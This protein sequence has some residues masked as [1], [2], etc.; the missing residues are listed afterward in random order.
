[1][2]ILRSNFSSLPFPNISNLK[3]VFSKSKVQGG[4]FLMGGILAGN[5]RASQRVSKGNIMSRKRKYL[6]NPSFQLSPD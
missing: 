1:M 5:E 4:H 3:T 6:I 2:V